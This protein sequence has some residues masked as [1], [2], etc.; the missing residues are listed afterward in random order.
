MDFNSFLEYLPQI[1]LAPLP[2]QKAHAI[3]APLQRMNFIKTALSPDAIPRTAS[4]LL[5]LYPKNAS[6]HLV[7]ILRTTYTG[8]HSAQVAFPGGKFETED[9]TLERTALRETHEEIGVLPQKIK[10]I[11]Q[12]TPTYIPPSNFMVHPFLGI[13]TD[14]L[15]FFPDPKE[16]SEI[17]EWPLS[18]LL[19]EETVVQE[20]IATSYM[21]AL[22][23]PCFVIQDH[24][25]WGATAMILSE[26]KELLKTVLVK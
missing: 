20:K 9:S 15:Q 4:V 10:I 14:E 23:V 19:Q 24:L 26:L 5:L 21:A 7:L 25:V 3:M 1:T 17:I 22:E 12:F 2:G 18:N 11:K 13:A 6:T 8:V 16:V